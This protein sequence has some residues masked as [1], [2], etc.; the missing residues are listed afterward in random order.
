M[1]KLERRILW[2]MIFGIV[3][4]AAIGLLTDARALAAELLHFPFTTFLGALG[5]TLVNYALRFG[6]WH[7]YLNKL[8]FKIAPLHSLNVFLAGLAMSVTPGKVGEVLKSLLLRESHQI[9]AA[10]TAP[11]VIAERLT[12]LLG[13]FVIAAFGVASFEFGR[14]VFVVSVGVVCVAILVLQQP[15]LVHKI[16]DLVERL[17]VLGPMRTKFDEAYTSMQK[18]LTLPVL[19]WTTLLSVLAWSMEA[20]AFY[21]ILTTLGATDMTLYL[22]FFI[23]AITTILGAV[24]FLPGGLGVTE[25]SMIGVLLLLGSFTARSTAAAATYL[26]RFA[27]LWFGVIL[28]FIALLIFRFRLRNLQTINSDSADVESTS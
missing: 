25:G 18:L 11:I 20:L 27:T 19:A 22:A 7:Y 2:G 24:S 23:Y 9:P 12:D 16:L 26:I 21:W 13:L 14:P 3:T 15:R 8:G 1:N 6:K 10:Q 5:L 4:Y 28:G 17:P